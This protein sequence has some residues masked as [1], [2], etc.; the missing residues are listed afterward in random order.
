MVGANKSFKQLLDVLRDMLLE[1]TQI[2]E[3]FYE[4]KKIT[5]PLGTKRKNEEDY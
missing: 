2:G 5:C 1:G 3:S 4:A